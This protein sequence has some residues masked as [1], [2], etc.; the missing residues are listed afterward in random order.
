MNN[1][2][3]FRML[4]PVSDEDLNKQHYVSPSPA[5][6]AFYNSFSTSEQ[7][8]E[9]AF[10][11]FKTRPIMYNIEG[12][13]S[14]YSSDN[15]TRPS[16]M[17][18]LID[19]RTRIPL[20]EDKID[21]NKIF[22]SELNGL[23]TIEADQTKI[24]KM[25]ERRLMESLTEKGKFGLTE[26]DIEA[27]ATL[28]A[29]RAN[30]TSINKEKTNIKKVIAELKIK[31]AQHAGETSAV[32]GNGKGGDATDF[33]KFMLDNI[34]NIPSTQ[35]PALPANTSTPTNAETP[36][37]PTTAINYTP[38]DDS[39]ARDII[40]KVFPTVSDEVAYERDGVRLCVV[41]DEPG[42][43]KYTFEARDR[44]NNPVPGYDIPSDLEITDI[45]PET[46]KAIDNR[47]RELEVIYRSEMED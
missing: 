7:S 27:M 2:D 34:F 44:D 1:V 18:A 41:Y 19:D 47:K 30:L 28:N 33:G 15:W 21:P 24:T 39:G 29:A 9:D 43:D 22:N 36:V 5:T 14:P 12:Y 23:R 31:Q 6:P 46:H 38:I 4:G 16:S 8:W 11:S 13:C 17:M 32:T 42:S 3:M 10:K 37:I 35:Q 20:V 40:D 45:I 25:F 26:E